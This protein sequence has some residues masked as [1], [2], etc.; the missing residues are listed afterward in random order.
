MAIDTKT[1]I[2]LRQ[3]TGAGVTD[4][5]EALVQSHGDIDGAIEILR[6]KGTLKAATKAEREA[7]EGIIDAAVSADHSHG[8]LLQIHCE[9]DFV[10]KNSIFIDFVK[11]I[12]DRSLAEFQDP[13]QLFTAESQSI[14]LQTGENIVFG[15]AAKLSGGYI[16]SYIHPNRKVAVLVQFKKKVDQE[17][18]RD[19]AMHIAAVNPAYLSSQD[20]PAEILQKEREIYRALLRNEKKPDEMAEKII[21]GKIKKF[22]DE[23]CLLNQSFIKAE[24]MTVEKLLEQKHAAVTKFVRFQIAA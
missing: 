6:K 15:Q 8:V 22:H 9:T 18:G 10:A 20:I 11:N 14:I 19:I 5:Q 13:Q 2:Q 16:D 7:R 21:Q 23:N 17:L 1:L 24:D 4:C 3:L 12:S